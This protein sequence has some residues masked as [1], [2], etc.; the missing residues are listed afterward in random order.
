MPF[1]SSQYAWLSAAFLRS[2]S[3]ASQVGIWTPLK[4]SPAA[5]P[6]MAFRLLNGG[7]SPANCARNIAGPLIVLIARF[8]RKGE[9][10][11]TRKEDPS[12]RPFGAGTD[13][14]SDPATPPPWSPR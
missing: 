7:A 12:L 2:N 8:S 6:A 10:K 14:A 11:Y 5:Q 1:T 9:E 3:R 13:A 4:P